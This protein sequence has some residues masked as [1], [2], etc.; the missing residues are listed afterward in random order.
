MVSLL[1]GYFYNFFQAS[2]DEDIRPWLIGVLVIS[3]LLSLIGAGKSFYS[4][5]KVILRK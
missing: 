5:I 2:V 3:T 1:Y 4:Q